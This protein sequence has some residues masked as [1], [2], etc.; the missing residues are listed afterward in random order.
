VREIAYSQIHVTVVI[1]ISPIG[2]HSMPEIVVVISRDAACLGQSTNFRKSSVLVVFIKKIGR[3]TVCCYKNICP[4]VIVIVT[5][6]AAPT[7]IVRSGFACRNTG[8][9]SDIFKFP[10][11]EVFK[12]LIGIINFV[13]VNGSS[14]VCYEQIKQ[15]VVVIIQP[16]GRNSRLIKHD[17]FIRFFVEC[18]V[19]ISP[20]YFIIAVT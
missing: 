14:A 8:G 9:L 17:R 19:L 15:A 12:K 20:I 5:Y 2:S 18:S 11:S 10:V 1:I 6:T 16:H 13:P 4:T 3:E 7:I